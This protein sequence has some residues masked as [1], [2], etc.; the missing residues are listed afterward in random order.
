[1]RR[2]LP[3]LLLVLALP[4]LAG[5]NLLELTPTSRVVRTR[6]AGIAAEPAEIALGESTTLTALLVHPEQPAPD[7]GQLWFACVE[8]GGAT[9]CLGL[10]PSTF[11]G[12]GDDDDD[13]T[14]PDDVDPRDL[15]FGVG[16]EFT[17]TAHGSTIE[18]AWA[19][20]EPEERVEGLTVF[21][22][23]NFV[24]A[25]NERLEQM[26]LELGGALQSGDTE[27]ADAIGEQLQELLEDPI[28]AARRVVVSDK[29][30]DVPDVI[31]CP[32]TELLPN[33]NPIIADVLLHLDEEGN[34]VGFP[35]GPVTFVEPGTDLVLRPLLR[36]DA[37]EDYLYIN[38]FDETECR[39]ETPYFAWLTNGDGVDSDYTFVAEEGDLDEVEG[40]AKT[41]HLHLP[42][43]DRFGD[44]VDLWLVVRD[45]RGGLTWTHRTFV[46]LDE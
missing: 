13:D 42:P 29:T 39:F 23:V 40:R 44:S 27:T 38:R 41:N 33:T 25:S 26:M 10:D 30:A 43:A 34:D 7:R 31:T 35:L 16:E 11:T 6:V 12:G 2:R 37:R 22:S 8:A 24:A 14:V 1:M 4:T 20:L 28:S 18:E 45:R 3:L 9:G 5:C 15:Q 46:P 21:V 17:Y 32:A 36:E 19:A